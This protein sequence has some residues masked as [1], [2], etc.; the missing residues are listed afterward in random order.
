MNT[1]LRLMKKSL[2]ASLITG[3]VATLA[4][5]PTIA[6]AQTANATLRGTG[7]ANTEVT[8][9]NVATGA[10]RRTRTGADGSYALPGLQ[11]GTYQIDAGPGTERTVT[12]TVASTAT[13]NLQAAPAAPAAPSAAN[14]STLGTVVVTGTTLQEVKTSEVGNTI[15]LHQIQTIPQVS[16]NFLEFADTVPGMVFQVDSSGHTQLRGGAQNTS[17]VNVYIDGVG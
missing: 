15:S 16:R 1:T 7:P 4:A 3:A 5:A 11:P 13:L 12:L 14:A 17:S 2:L 8:A 10:T 9:R 6:W